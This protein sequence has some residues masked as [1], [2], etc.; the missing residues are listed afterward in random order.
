[1]K[2]AYHLCIMMC[3]LILTV[4]FVSTFERRVSKKTKQATVRSIPIINMDVSPND[5]ILAQATCADRYLARVRCKARQMRLK[6]DQ[7]AF[8]MDKCETVSLKRLLLSKKANKGNHSQ[9]INYVK[10]DLQQMEILKKKMKVTNDF[11]EAAFMM[12]KI[13]RHEK[14]IVK[15]LLGAVHKTY[16]IPL[17]VRLLALRKEQE[18]L[19][20]MNN[21]TDTNKDIIT[22]ARVLIKRVDDAMNKPL[23]GGKKPE[24]CQ[25]VNSISFNVLKLVGVKP[26]YPGI[27]IIQKPIVNKNASV[28]ISAPSQQPTINQKA[29]NTG[30]ISNSQATI[31]LK[32]GNTSTISNSQGYQV[33]SNRYTQNNL[34]TQMPPS[35]SAFLRNPA[36]VYDQRVSWVD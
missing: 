4:T 16:K 35:Q 27:N 36:S 23:V 18:I 6:I 22:E 20:A 34:A 29:G 8:C 7:D 24:I 1:M 13:R 28:S 14:H 32:A 2:Q 31:N 30:T 25:G 15:T 10:K 26:R 9:A 5:P 17:G 3:V 12:S 33:Q 11:D 19:R 21:P